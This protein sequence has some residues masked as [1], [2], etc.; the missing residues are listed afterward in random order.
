MDYGKWLT[1]GTVWLA[2]S[3]YVA[4][5]I[6]RSTTN[7]TRS[8]VIGRTLN[9]LGFAAFLAHVALAFHFYHHWSHAAAYA[10][11]ARQTK[12]YFG[13]DWGGGLFFNYLFLLFWAGQAVSSWTSAVEVPRKIG[14]LGWLMRGFVLLMTLNGAVIFAHGTVRWFGLLLNLILIGCWWPRHSHV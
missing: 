1:R 3:L 2:L 6:V 12:H 14:P 8:A 13:L 10:D 5:E 7:E 4:A 11:T 9:S